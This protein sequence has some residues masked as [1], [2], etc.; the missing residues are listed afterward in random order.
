MAKK[1][2]SKKRNE[3]KTEKMISEKKTPKPIEKWAILE[4][5]VSIKIMNI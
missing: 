4:L 1:I 3:T 5:R 2:D